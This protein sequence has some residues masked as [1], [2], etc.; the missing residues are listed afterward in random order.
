VRFERVDRRL[1]FGRSLTKSP[2]LCLHHG[3]E[4]RGEVARVRI[5]LR[6]RIAI[7]LAAMTKASK[8]SKPC[9]HSSVSI[10]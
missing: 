7:L 5:A 6:T 9:L 1:K 8:R 10:T 2:K 4:V 3:V